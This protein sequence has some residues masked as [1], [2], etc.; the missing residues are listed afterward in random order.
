MSTPQDSSAVTLDDIMH[1]INN[2]SNDL[3]ATKLRV[4]EL[5]TPKQPLQEL[6][7]RRPPG[8]PQPGWRP[9]PSRTTPPTFDPTPRMRVDAPR[10]SGE[11]PTG[12]I[13]RVQKYFDYF[14]TPEPE[15]FQLVAM[16][17][18]HPASEWFHYYQ[19]NNI[20]ASW[21][22]FLE[23]V[24]QR[25]DPD[26]YENYVGLLSKLTQTTTVMEYQT[27]FEAILNK[28]SGV[29]ESTLVAMYVAGLK[30]P[31]QRELNLR[32]PSTLQAT[33]ALA[34]ELSAYDDDVPS[35]DTET[36]EDTTD[37]VH[38]AADIS[39]MHSMTGSPSPRSLRLAGLVNH[40]AV[41]QG[42]PLAFF[43]KKLG[44]R[45]RAASTYHKELYAI[46]EA[47]QK[48]RQYLLGREFVIRS[49]QRSL[50]EL[51]AQIVQ[52]PDQQFYLRKL[53][54][55]KF[56]I[57]YKKG[58]TN[59]AADALSRR[60]CEEETAGLFNTYAQPVPHIMQALRWENASLPDLQELHSAVTAGTAPSDVSAHDGLLYFKRRLYVSPTSSL[61]DQLLHEFHSTPVA[62]HQGR[63]RTFRRLAQVFYWPSMRKDVRRFVA[64]CLVCQ[65]TKYSTQ[66]PAGLLQPL[67]IPSQ[68]GFDAP[69]V[70]QLF[71]EVVV[72]H[73]GFPT[74]LV[75]DRDSVFM[76]SFWRELMRL[77]GTSLKFSTAYHPQS[78]G[79]TEVVN[80]SVEQYLRAFTF[81]R[82]SKWAHFLPWAELALNCSHHEGLG[83]SPF[84]ALYGRPPPSLFP[85]L[86]V[87][88]K[89]PRVEEILSERADLLHDLKAQLEKMQHRMRAQ[90]NR[91]RRDVEYVVGDLVLLKLHPYR[92][93]SLA[94][95]VSAKL[96]QRFYGP[97][98]VVERVVATLPDAFFK[99][100]P[101][102]TPVTAIA[103]RVVMVDG[104]SQEQ[105][106]IRWSDGS[107]SDTTWEP[108]TALRE[109]F[110]DLCLEDKDASNP[111]GVDTGTGAANAEVVTITERPQ[112][113]VKPPKRYQDYI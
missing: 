96:A 60:D 99:G 82:P 109:H 48:W 55:F 43:S 35:P 1:A 74:S 21:Q 27:A 92:Q 5:A 98:Q 25:F 29:P 101:I 64:S 17:I 100:R 45:R 106:L 14:L 11:D 13:F 12:W 63:E 108:V 26:Y 52:T 39:S 76:G 67:P 28:V 95:R 20:E 85:T 2:L 105:W 59:R 44:P 65:M 61:R 97:F 111:G 71:V 10:F 53:M 62:G 103:S 66:K 19:A 40:G 80:R 69:R 51:L 56:R 75:S 33:F 84:Q 73:H 93:H 78:D 87:R 68:T 46:V 79:Q 54:G 23:A 32:N 88:S 89:D 57:E 94:R 22:E 58:A 107:D 9:P 86:A 16:L 3:Q 30:Q 24:H 110:P 34:R 90:A 113:Q 7:Q 81:E 49:D 8:V 4:A 77:S 37:S 47:V 50:K 102:S 6:E 31:V 104:N 18:D 41:Q 15:R 72:K 38:I 42:H 112:R 91:H 36:P 83:L 70:A